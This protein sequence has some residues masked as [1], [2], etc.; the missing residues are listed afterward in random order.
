MRYQQCAADLH[1]H[2]EHKNI[3]VW[4]ISVHPTQCAALQDHSQEGEQ[5]PIY[6]VL[7][8][9]FILFY[10]LQQFRAAEEEKWLGSLWTTVGRTQQ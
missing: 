3:Q 10:I 4:A 9:V 7:L 8:P 6:H 5:I 1:Q 2:Y